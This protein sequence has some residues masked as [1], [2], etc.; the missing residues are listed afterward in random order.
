MI[1]N[2]HRPALVQRPISRG[3]R[4]LIGAAIGTAVALPVSTAAKY[5][6]YPPARL[7]L[8]LVAIAA[9][10][11]GALVGFFKKA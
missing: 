10:I 2:N 5:V 4:S 1:S 11:A 6:P 7:L 8:A 9:P 3:D